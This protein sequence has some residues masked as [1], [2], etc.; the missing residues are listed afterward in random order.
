[1]N[2]TTKPARYLLNGEI[3]HYKRFWRRGR[4]LSQRLEQIVIETKMNLRDIAFKYS[5]GL[6]T[7]QTDYLGPLY[8]EH[9]SEV[10][11]GIRNTPRY[12]FA[13]EDS[14][15]LPIETIRKIY[16]EDKEREKLGQVLDPDSIRE[17]VIWYS[18]VLKS[19]RAQ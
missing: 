2:S 15:K 7:D 3:V 1:M 19:N 17:F 18:E 5:F 13:I 8:R 14:W 12:A 9:L 16:R 4:S 6:N 11:K 10:V